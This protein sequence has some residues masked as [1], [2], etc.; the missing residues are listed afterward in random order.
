MDGHP[1]PQYPPGMVL[2]DNGLRNTINEHPSCSPT[3]ARI[4]PPPFL[5][6]NLFAEQYYDAS[7]EV[8]E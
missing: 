2:G 7:A 4:V 8:T 5:A 3:Q 6:T 1:S